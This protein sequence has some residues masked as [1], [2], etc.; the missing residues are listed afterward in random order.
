MIDLCRF[1]GDNLLASFYQILPEHSLIYASYSDTV[2]TDE[3]LRVV[4][5]VMD[6]PD[7]RVEFKQLIDLTEL[8]EI[9]LDYVKVMKAQA[10]MADLIANARC[11]ILS[12]VVA[13][14]PVALEAAKMVLRSW[15][16]QDTPVVRRIVSDM[17]KA[18]ILLG[19][20]KNKYRDLIQQLT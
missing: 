5:G 9:R 3:Y 14:T 16:G 1:T 17:S 4:N 12:V 11:D 18:A 7:F 2:V 8:K 15:D 6:H 19:F 13:P 10:R 20:G